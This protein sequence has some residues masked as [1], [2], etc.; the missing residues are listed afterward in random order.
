MVVLKIELSILN[1]ITENK[2]FYGC[3]E[4]ILDT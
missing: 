1:H 3:Q 4:K 2:I